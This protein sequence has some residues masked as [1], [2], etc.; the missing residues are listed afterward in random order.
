MVQ[1]LRLR[2]DAGRSG[3]C[4]VWVWAVL[5]WLAAFLAACPLISS[6]WD[7][8]TEDSTA[9]WTQCNFPY[10]SWEWRWFTSFTAFLLPAFV[11]VGVYFAI[12]WQLCRHRYSMGSSMGRSGVELRLTL[13]IGVITVCYLLCCGPYAYYFISGLAT[14]QKLKF[15]FELAEFIF[16]MNSL[17]NPILYMSIQKDISKSVISLL[18]FVCGFSTAPPYSNAQEQQEMDHLRP[19]D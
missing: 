15:Q 13:V 1:S 8:R 12:V 18:R 5:C 14:Q 6:S 7:D 3:R 11:I 16:Y 4:S 10:Q 17:T 9:G 2:P 19:P